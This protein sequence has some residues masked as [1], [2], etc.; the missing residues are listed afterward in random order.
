MS[1]Q[2]P[3]DEQPEA[4]AGTPVVEPTPVPDLLRNAG[5]VF[6]GGGLGALTRAGLIELFPANASSWTVLAINLVGSFIFAWLATALLARHRRILLFFGTGFLGGFTTYSTLALDLASRVIAADYLGLALL[7]V[8]SLAGGV[9]LAR[10][11]WLLGRMR[12][13]SQSHG[14]DSSG[15]GDIDLPPTV[16]GGTAVAP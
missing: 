5:L 1:S 10:L 12:Q 13:D 4:A 15:P 9:A 7:A 14:N 8:F 3:A 11:G 6:V 16:P 2:P